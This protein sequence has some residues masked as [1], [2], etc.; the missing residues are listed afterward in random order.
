VVIAIDEIE[1]CHEEEGEGR[2]GLE[3]G[4]RPT[5][6]KV[7]RGWRRLAGT[8]G[9]GGWQA[10]A[11]QARASR[12]IAGRNRLPDCKRFPKNHISKCLKKLEKNILVSYILCSIKFHERNIFFM[13]CAKTTILVLQNCYL[14]D[15]IGFYDTRHKKY[16]F[17]ANSV[18][19]P[20]ML[21]MKFSVQFFDILKCI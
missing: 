6:Q 1:G 2:E 5:G 16:P 9:G 12:P 20:R 4:G 13:A 18:G 15:F 8:K 3:V 14:C 19:E 21:H 11:R 10:R 7:R 17:S